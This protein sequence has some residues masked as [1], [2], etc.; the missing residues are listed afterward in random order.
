MSKTPDP[1]STGASG[2][3]GGDKSARE[4]ATIKVPS[5]DP[6]KKDDKKDEDLVSI[7]ATTEL[8]QN[9]SVYVLIIS[10]IY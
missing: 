2:S 7:K 5:K 1:N 8:E 6:K 10:F 9:C 3:A 4:E